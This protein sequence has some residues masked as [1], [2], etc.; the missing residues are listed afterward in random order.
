MT[1]V[2]LQD[3]EA[4]DPA[5]TGGKGA[6]LARLLA[7]GFLVPPGFCVTTNACARI[8]EGDTGYRDRLRARIAH[9]VRQI[10][11]ADPAA[12]FAVRSSST[13]EDGANA[14]F[15][16]QYETRLGVAPEDIGDAVVEV[17][18]SAKA[19]H[20]RE[21]RVYRGASD[22]AMAVVVQQMVRAER[23]GVCFTK[24]PVTAKD[25][26]LVSANF[27]LGETVVNGEITPD[28]YVIDRRTMSVGS[29]SIGSKGRRT[30]LAPSGTTTVENRVEERAAPCLSDAEACEVARL[31]LRVEAL[32]EAPV[33]IEWAFEGERLFLLQARP[34]TTLDSRTSGPP[35]GWAPTDNTPID[36]TYPL[37]SNGN[38]SEVLPGCVT[39]LSW[40]HTGQL[41]EHAFLSQLHSLGAIERN[42]SPRALGFFFHRPYVNVSLLLEAASR[43]PGMTEDTVLEEFIGKPETRTPPVGWRD[44]LP[45]RLPRLLRVLAVVMLR[46]W[47]LPRAI[48]VSCRTAETE[49][50]RVDDAWLESAS[51]Q[52]LLELTKMTDTLAAPSV[53]HV[54]ASTLASVAFAQL[55]ATL[56]KW[57]QDDEGALASALVSGIDA[58]PSAAPGASLHALGQRVRADQTLTAALV[59]APSDQDAYRRL[60]ESELGSELREFLLQYGHRGVAEAELS[61][62]CWREDPSQ[63]VALLRNHL[64]DGA[65]APKSIQERHSRARAEANDRLR[66]L[67]WWRRAVV[68]W[69]TRRA[70]E[71][72][73]N[74]ET[75]KD[76]VIRRLD[77]SRRAYAELNRRLVSRRLLTEKTDIFFLRWEEIDRLVSGALSPDAASGI[78]SQRRR[79]FN[80]SKRVA[81]PKIQERVPRTIAL[82]E[83]AASIELRGMGVSAGQVTGVARV[84]TDPRQD[85]RLEPGEIL[86]APVTDV[87]WTPLFA[88]AAG[89][90]VEVGGLLS[91]GSIVAREYGMPAIVGVNGATQAIQTGDRVSLDGRTG[92][93]RKL[94]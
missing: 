69:M 41:I 85:A 29:R 31:A 14:S 34:I 64:R 74:R 60:S 71:G 82:D 17:C 4:R 59:G 20:A 27:G 68:V 48:A 67:P 50:A 84:V 24:D 55:R 91:H 56:S 77:R 89:L 44:L 21:Y 11:D 92:V 37:Y 16:G 8:V 12:R 83:L 49:A 36:P 66:V 63:V 28:S 33:D 93:V 43:T 1:V 86:V 46:T 81:V 52:S 3:T 32:H 94:A 70:R 35:K 38:I 26:V 6:E 76:V 9:A 2:A 39:P 47:T 65:V 53:V 73:L 45:N 54:W 10:V 51:D 19:A 90:V 42:A 7:E 25:H 13:S 72:L 5:L 78:V 30:V 15:A 80:W 87:A 75:M 18:R 88:Q 23:A 62:P 57:I 79:D 61:R 40:N 22:G 58:L